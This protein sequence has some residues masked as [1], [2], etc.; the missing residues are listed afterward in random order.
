MFLRDEAKRMQHSFTLAMIY[1]RTKLVHLV[2]A[3]LK[4]L[5]LGW[6]LR[7]VTSLIDSLPRRTIT[8]LSP[9]FFITR[10]KCHPPQRDINP[11]SL[12]LSSLIYPH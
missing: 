4:K 10:V 1:R 2:S 9:V 11:R 7:A 6:V 8:L 5:L 12:P 3:P